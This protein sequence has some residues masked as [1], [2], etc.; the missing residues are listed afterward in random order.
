ML[1]KGAKK[2]YP[3]LELEMFKRKITVRDLARRIG[4]SESSM[5][6]KL[7]GRNE[8]L[9]SEMKKILDIF[10]DVDWRVLFARADEKGKA[11]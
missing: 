9:L 7:K 3:N 11:G 2:V 6:N 5:H 10:P 8:F 1:K 4:I